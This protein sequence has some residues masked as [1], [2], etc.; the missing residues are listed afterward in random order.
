MLRALNSA[1]GPKT[2]F[3]D[4]TVKFMGPAGAAIARVHSWD[5]GDGPGRRA[6]NIADTRRRARTMMVEDD[7]LDAE[8]MVRLG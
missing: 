2:A 8:R 3:A 6:Y 4:R 1:F 7:A 5:K